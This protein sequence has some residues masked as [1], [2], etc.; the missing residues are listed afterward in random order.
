MDL[1]KEKGRNK[2]REKRFVPGQ[3]QFHFVDLDLNLKYIEGQSF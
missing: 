3:R 1:Q 2:K